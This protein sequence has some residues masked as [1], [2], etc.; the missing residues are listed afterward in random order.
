MV[1]TWL[2]HQSGSRALLTA[3]TAF[4]DYG[5]PPPCQEKKK[6]KKKKS[7]QKKRKQQSKI[8]RWKPKEASDSPLEKLFYLMAHGKVIESHYCSKRAN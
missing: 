5:K 7:S 6:K 1:A 4:F 8:S 3:A 2:V